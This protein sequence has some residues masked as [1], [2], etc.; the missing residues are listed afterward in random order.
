MIR[1]NF[2]THTTWCDGNNSVDEMARAAVGLG[3]SALGFSGHSPVFYEPYFGMSKADVPRYA[4]SVRA[5]KERYAGQ[6]DIFLGVEDDFHGERPAFERDYTIGSVH[7]VL[8]GGIYHP[9]DVS[10]ALLRKAVDRSFGGDPYA[11]CRAYFQNVAEV[12]ERTHCDFVGHFDLVT[13][14]NHGVFDEDDPRYLGPALEALEAVCRDG[15]MLE[16][17]TGAMTRGLRRVPYPAP[18]LLRA[19]RK[20]GGAIVLSSDCH[21]AKNLL[22]CF[23]EA[24]ALAR[25]C[26][27]QTARVLT[28]DGWREEAL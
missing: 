16:V 3:M 28:G 21:D 23:G 2:H 13:R 27:F 6:L 5:A 24:A 11:L 20:F 22:S 18:R 26:G 9:M 7:C 14:Y 12:R 1:S 15:G 19:A 10:E 4:A 25:A 17:N 8:A